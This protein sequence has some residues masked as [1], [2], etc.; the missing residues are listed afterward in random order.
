MTELI[1]FGGILNVVVERMVHVTKVKD[2]ARETTSVPEILNVVIRT[3]IVTFQRTKLGGDGDTI[4]A[5]VRIIPILITSF[6]IDLIQ[7]V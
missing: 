6:I 3:A 2:I 1:G 5:F 4:A 7:V